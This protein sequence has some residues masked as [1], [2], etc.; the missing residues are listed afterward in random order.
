ITIPLL[1]IGLFVNV[2]DMFTSIEFAVIGAIA[3]Y[4][5]PWC[6]NAAFKYATGRDGMGMGDF[7][8]IAALGAWIGVSQLSLLLFSSSLL[9]LI[10]IVCVKAFLKQQLYKNESV[11]FGPFLAVSGIGIV[12]F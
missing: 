7:K 8:L 3:G 2:G 1:C 11:P 12:L 9:G 4:I 5:S 6:I 10:V